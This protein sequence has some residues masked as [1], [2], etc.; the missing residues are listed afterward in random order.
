MLIFICVYFGAYCNSTINDEM[1]VLPLR[2]INYRVAV[3]GQNFSAL[4]NLQ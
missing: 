4:F 2:Q 1:T 3:A